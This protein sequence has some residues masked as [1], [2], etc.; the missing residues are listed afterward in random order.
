MARYANKVLTLKDGGSLAGY[1][2]SAE[3][4]SQNPLKDD[5]SEETESTELEIKPESIPRPTKKP[6]EEDQN[7]LVKRKVWRRY[8]LGFTMENPLDYSQFCC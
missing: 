4:I 5:V 2:S 1:E 8:R 6:K 3:W 7:E